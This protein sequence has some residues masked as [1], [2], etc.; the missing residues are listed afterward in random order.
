MDAADAVIDLDND[1][2]L[3]CF[4]CSSFC[5][6]KAISYICL[7]WTFPTNECPGL[8]INEYNEFER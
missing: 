6:A 3:K 1:L 8:F 7:T 4:K 5:L 2:K